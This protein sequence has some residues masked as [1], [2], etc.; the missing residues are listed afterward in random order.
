MWPRVS[1]AVRERWTNVKAHN[2][3]NARGKAGTWPFEGTLVMTLVQVDRNVELQNQ[4]VTV[5]S[6]WCG[7]GVQMNHRLY[8][9]HNVS[10]DK[11][12][13]ADKIFLVLVHKQWDQHVHTNVQ[14]NRQRLLSMTMFL[15]CRELLDV[16][17]VR[18]NDNCRT[19]LATPNPKLRGLVNPRCDGE[20]RERGSMCPM[21]ACGARQMSMFSRQLFKAIQS[22]AARWL[23][24]SDSVRYPF[25]AIYQR[26]HGRGGEESFS[27]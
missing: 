20:K 22:V 4:G 3:E 26:C 16:A 8:F 10:S 14:H 25:S 6:L 27:V 9:F 12:V 7:S 23:V 18:A 13:R 21:T 15:L 5:G 17:C 2:I 24:I 1:V 11:S 19:L